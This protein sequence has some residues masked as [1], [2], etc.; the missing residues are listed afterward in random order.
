MK[1]LVT[2]ATGSLGLPLSIWLQERGHQVTAIG[3]Q[4]SRLQILRDHH[5]TA[6]SADL[7][8]DDLRDVVAAQDAVVHSAAL[9]RPWGPASDFTG[10]NLEA[11]R[12]LMTWS[13]ETGA[14]K[15]IHISTTAVYYDGTSK[16]G[17]TE[18]SPVPT[19]HPVQY[20][21]TKWASEKI[22]AEFHARGLSVLTLRPR[23]ILSPYDQTLLPRIKPLLE[24]GRFPLINGGHGRIDVTPVESICEAVLKALEALPRFS[25]EVYNL[26]N[27]EPIEIRELIQWVSEAINQPVRFVPVPGG[28]LRAVAHGIEWVWR[29]RETEPPLSRYALDLI[30]KS[31]SFDISKIKRDLGY[32]PA[33]STKE[34]IFRT[35]AHF[36]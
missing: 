1:I 16:T 17:L 14:K 30:S 27:D 36:R 19:S 5:V 8:R 24:R 35:G 15:F 2:G 33:L 21:A 6:L 28:V 22:A 25:G 29:G 9:T 10:P 20:A 11:T 32:R 4:A 26:T 12:R 34:A 13:L 31:Q 3:R 23:A 18:D 7:C